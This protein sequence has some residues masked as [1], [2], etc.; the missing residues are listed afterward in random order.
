IQTVLRYLPSKN[1]GVQLVLNGPSQ[2]CSH[3]VWASVWEYEQLNGGQ[4]DNSLKSRA[5][6]KIYARE[7]SFDKPGARYNRE[8]LGKMT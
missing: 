6:R 3:R 5:S 8:A 7:V 2:I 4:T 1:G